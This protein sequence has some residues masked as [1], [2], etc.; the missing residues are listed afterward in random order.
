[1][2]SS[3]VK[4]KV[5]VTLTSE[6]NMVHSAQLMMQKAAILLLDN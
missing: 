3:E 5:I 6:L 1:M 4:A 2:L